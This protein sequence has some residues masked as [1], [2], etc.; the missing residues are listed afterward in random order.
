MTP[1]SPLPADVRVREVVKRYGSTLAVDRVSF[2]VERGHV[3][4][5]LGPSGCGKTTVLRMIAGLI[6]PDAGDITIKDP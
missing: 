6:A 3:L 4:S 5:L 1:M 2:D